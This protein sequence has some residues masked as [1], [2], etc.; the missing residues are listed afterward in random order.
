MLKYCQPLAFSSSPVT[1][2]FSA[3]HYFRYTELS[4]NA[5]FR[6]RIRIQVLAKAL[7]KTM[8][9]MEG[10]CPSR[11]LLPGLSPPRRLSR[12]ADTGSVD[13][14]LSALDI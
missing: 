6:Y 10:F 5:K 12:T 4:L 11:T 2:S 14:A 7:I 9:I 8:H 13:E 3:I 1:H